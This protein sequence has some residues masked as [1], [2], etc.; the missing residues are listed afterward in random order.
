M[1]AFNNFSAD[2]STL[3]KSCTSD[4][5]I[6]ALQVSFV[7][8][9]RCNCRSRAACTRLRNSLRV[10]NL[11]FI[12]QLL[13]INTGDLHVNIDAIQERAADAFLV[14]GD[15]GGGATAFF[16]G[17]PVEAAGAGMQGSCCNLHLIHLLSKHVLVQLSRGGTREESRR[18]A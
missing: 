15:R 13:I 12:S 8:V 16:D 10:L 7:P 5:P 17:I 11:P 9:K 1:A 3:Q 2:G 6:S 18:A 4:G 14:A